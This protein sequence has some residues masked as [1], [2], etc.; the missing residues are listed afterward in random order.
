MGSTLNFTISTILAYVP[1]VIS[2]IKMVLCNFLVAIEIINHIHF[3]MVIVLNIFDV[4][5]HDG[6]KHI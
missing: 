2:L 3:Y 6:V 5:V 4:H 1:L